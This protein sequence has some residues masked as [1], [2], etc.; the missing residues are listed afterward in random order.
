MLHDVDPKEVHIHIDV[1]IDRTEVAEHDAYIPIPETYEAMDVQALV[2]REVEDA[3]FALNR[4]RFGRSPARK[5]L[6][7]AAARLRALE[8]LVG[9]M[10]RTGEFLQYRE[11]IRQFLEMSND[12][13]TALWGEDPE[14]D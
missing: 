10:P 8:A 14:G 1:R 5:A 3:A 12:E 11:R 9:E 13:V 6:I 2:A 4:K 7:A